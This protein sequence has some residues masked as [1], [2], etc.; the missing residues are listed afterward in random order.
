M[1]SENTPAIAAGRM[2]LARHGAKKRSLRGICVM[3]VEILRTLAILTT[4]GV[5]AFFLISKYRAL[6][7]AFLRRENKTLRETFIEGWNEQELNEHAKRNMFGTPG[8]TLIGRL[9]VFGITFL[10]LLAMAYCRPLAAILAGYIAVGMII[11]SR[12]GLTENDV[13]PR[14]SLNDRFVFRTLYGAFWPWYIL[15]SKSGS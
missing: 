14:L 10:F 6:I 12:K 9:I 3:D 13:Y 2:S 4:C 1:I 5:L 11:T 8:A 7:D 15:K